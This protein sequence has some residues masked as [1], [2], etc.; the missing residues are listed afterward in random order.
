MMIICRNYNII[1]QIKSGR[2]V[3]Q[4]IYS[5]FMV[6]TAIFWLVMPAYG[7][8]IS[9]D[10][11]RLINQHN[12]KYDQNADNGNQNGEMWCA[13]VA[14]VSALLWLAKQYNAPKLIPTDANGKPFTT[15]Q[16]ITYLATRW[17]YT[18]DLNGTTERNIVRG[19]W[20]YLKTTPYKWQMNVYSDPKT[21]QPLWAGPIFSDHATF[22]D[23]YREMKGSPVLLGYQH[24]DAL[25]KVTKHATVLQSIDDKKI[26][27]V[28]H[29]P[30]KIMDPYFGRLDD[31]W[32]D[33]SNGLE[34]SARL[35]DMVAWQNI[36]L[37][38]SIQPIPEPGTMILFG[39]GLI[40]VAGVTRRRKKKQI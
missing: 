30:G 17:L 21:V 14:S 20:G 24:K 9:H 39:T 34:S 15:D 3:L 33:S 8:P 18:H 1:W 4:F 11:L 26:D 37:A 40:G 12:K 5:F 35:Y 36:Y 25:G 13:P 23:L 22:Q 32:F 6:F 29:Y 7:T 27:A 19:L 38:V 16:F 28:K 2:R 10:G 31:V